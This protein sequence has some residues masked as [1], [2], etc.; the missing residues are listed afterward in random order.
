[1]WTMIFSFTFV[2][3]AMYLGEVVSKKTSGKVPQMLIV[4]LIFLVGF[5]TVVPKDVLVT[6]NITPF[7]DLMFGFVLIH[8][9]SMFSFKSLKKEWKTAIVTLVA[10]IGIV[11]MV[12][13]VGSMLF[14]K[15][16]GFSAA[17][18]MTGGGIAAIIIDKAATAANRPELGV[19]AM[20]IFIMHGFFGFPLTALMLN[21]E[22]NE[23]LADYRGDADKASHQEQSIDEE[24]AENDKKPTLIE[25]IPE[26]YRTT[27]WYLL[28]LGFWAVICSS[29]TAATGINNA[30]VQVVFGIVLGNL[31]LIEPGLLD[32]TNS[33]GI[34][35]LGLLAGFM[36]SFAYAT[37]QLV[38]QYFIKIVVLM[39]LATIAICLTAIP[40]GKYFGYSKWLSIAIGLNC[41]LGFPF[42]Y[43]ITVDAIKG[44]AKTEDEAMFLNQLLLPKMILAGII[45]VSIVSAV[46]AGIITSIIF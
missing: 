9:G 36:G 38:G 26:K 14:G 12:M 6:G 11:A 32:K 1:M 22:C 37:P 33:G 5:W 45:S 39:A 13:V 24:T 30:I 18:P 20:M 40:V 44:T 15:D 43:S 35:N 19:L 4:A 27:T 8:V 10:I 25:R 23:Q 2:I 28:Q 29:I 34:L 21:K 7:Y 17:A 3:L 16:I 42:N 31:G 41:F 46:L